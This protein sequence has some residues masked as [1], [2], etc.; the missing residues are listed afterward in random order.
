MKGVP[1]AILVIAA[2]TSCSVS[3]DPQRKTA[4]LLQKGKLREDTSWVYALPYKEGGSHLLVQGYFSRLSHK[5]RAALDF[6]MKKGTEIYAARGGV[7]AR[8][9]KHNN[10][11][12]WNR[13]FR[14]Y[15]NLVVIDHADGTR[16]GYWH[17]QKEGVFVNVGD[18]VKAGQLI[19]LSGKTGY[20]ATPHLH[21]MVW[22]NNNGNWR[23]VPT[24]FM[25]KK[26]P[27]YLRPMHWYQKIK[28]SS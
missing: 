26:G 13:K 20:T 8:M 10:K 11:G 25:T 12:G 23:Q 6:K 28:V 9:V 7:V 5:H 15:A 14:Q 19:G 21:F 27:R 16:A 17:L 22:K 3:K 4:R 24:R 18:T 2:C 1:A